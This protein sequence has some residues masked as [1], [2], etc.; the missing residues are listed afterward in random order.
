M[1]KENSELKSRVSA[2][3]AELAGASSGTDKMQRRIRSLEKANDALTKTTTVYEHEKR[4]LEK[5]V[6][7]FS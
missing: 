3:E 1:E 6:C 7:I 4:Q 2:L 5:E